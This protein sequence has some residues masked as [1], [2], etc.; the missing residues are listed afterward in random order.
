MALVNVWHFLI[1]GS[2]KFVTFFN[3]EV[4]L[5]LRNKLLQN[6]RRFDIHYQICAVLIFAAFLCSWQNS[7]SKNTPKLGITRKFKEKLGI[8][9]RRGSVSSLKQLNFAK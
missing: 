2:T 5:I 9:G 1:R 4:F 3:F 7:L 6:S 8:V